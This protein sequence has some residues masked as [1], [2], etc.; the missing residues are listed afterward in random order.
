MTV[1]AVCWDW[2][3]T[4]LDDVD[5]CLRT[6]NSM[7]ATFGKP[8]IPDAAR[9]RSLFR[10]PIQSFYTDVGIRPDEYRDAV[11]HYLGLLE[12]DDSAVPLHTGA[13]EMLALVR[14]RGIPQVLAS[15]TQG[16]LLASQLHPHALDDAFDEVLSIDDA[17]NASKRDVIAAWLDRTGLASDAVLLVGD[18]NHD[19]EI[20]VELGARF[21]H[22]AGGHQKF[23]GFPEVPRIAALEQLEAHLG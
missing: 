3:C 21:V 1:R 23:A 19:H 14:S 11:D 2:I 13:R 17:H 10:F 4:L 5:R 8:V 16:P 20:A 22:F 15:A 9:Y 18:T 7:L 12:R 6:M